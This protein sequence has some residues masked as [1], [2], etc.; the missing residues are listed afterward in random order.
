MPL[1]C[2]IGGG[3]GGYSKHKGTE[4]SEDLQITLEIIAKDGLYKILNYNGSC[5]EFYTCICMCTCICTHKYLYICMCWCW[6]SSTVTL[7]LIF[8]TVL[9]LNPSLTNLLDWLARELQGS[10][11]SVCCPATPQCQR[12]NYDHIFTWVLG[13]I[14]QQAL[15][16]LIHLSNPFDYDICMCYICIYTYSICIYIMYIC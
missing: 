11:I 12:Y 6:M 10:P 5:P 8:E 14:S 9:S 4:A 16:S 15:D 1:M 3:M 2:V 7:Q 13:M